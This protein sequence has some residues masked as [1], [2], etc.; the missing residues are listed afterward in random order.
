MHP[1]YRPLTVI[2]EHGLADL[3]PQQ[4]TSTDPAAA[5]L[6]TARDILLAELN[7]DL[8]CSTR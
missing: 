4:Q 5:T 1:A 6:Q 7:P 8:T 3:L 2:E